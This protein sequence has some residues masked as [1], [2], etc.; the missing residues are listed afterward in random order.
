MRRLVSPAGVHGGIVTVV[1]LIGVGVNLV[2]TAFAARAD[3]SSLNIRGVLAHLITD[4]WAFGATFLA[5]VVVLTAGWTRAD[6]LA[7]LTVAALMAWT[8]WRLVSAAG[9][10]FLEAAPTGVDPG[11]LGAE[12]ARTDGVA[13]VHDL[14]VWEI[15]PG[16]VA[17]SAH[18]LVRPSHDCHE[19]AGALRTTL[20]DTHGIGHVTLQTDHVG[21]DQHVAEDCIDAHG[22]VHTPTI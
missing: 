9:R 4:L 11:A 14:H 6:A 12:L 17:L 5:G 2:A 22:S 7:S 1:A 3:R 10:V 13:S 8:G 21:A 18:V 15:G 16:A 19:V 20:R